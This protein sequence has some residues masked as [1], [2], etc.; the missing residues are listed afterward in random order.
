M[1]WNRS[2]ILA[3]AAVKCAHCGGEGLRPKTQGKP[4]PCNCVL[5]GIFRACFE[6]FSQCAN[7]DF[8]QSRISPESGA[9]RQAGGS[10]GRKNE[11][12]V[13]DFLLMAK[14]TLTED[15]HR[16][17]R[18]HHLLGADWRLCCRKLAVDKGTFFHS[19][20]RLQQKL[21]QALAETEPY[22]LFPV[23]DYFITGGRQEVKAKVLPIRQ[24]RTVLTEMVPLNR[25]A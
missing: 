10:W 22:A 8:N 17:F 16:I 1:E 7:Q 21:G 20:Y 3:M 13:A 24:E 23:R 4:A 2:E 25:A 9:S 18:Y 12:Y 14:R 6:R 19:L 11:E 15:E 5:R